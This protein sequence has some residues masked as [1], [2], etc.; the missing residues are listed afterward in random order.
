MYVCIY[1]H[2]GTDTRFEGGGI[3]VSNVSTHALYII[4]IVFI[5]DSYSCSANI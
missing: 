5:K 2:A 1:I 4:I 3:N